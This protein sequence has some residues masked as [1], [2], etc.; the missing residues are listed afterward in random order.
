MSENQ[1]CFQ[2]S[3]VVAISLKIDARYIVIIHVTIIKLF[4]DMA[5]ASDG[6]FI[7]YPA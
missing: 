3:G 6:T 1:N 5:L 7:K 4:L 2:N